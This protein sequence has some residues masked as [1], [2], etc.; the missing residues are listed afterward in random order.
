MADEN[1]GVFKAYITR[2]GEGP[3][4]TELLNET[5]DKIR[6]IGAEFGT[7]TGRPRRCGWFDGVVAKY[8]V[9]VSGLT[10]IAVT[11]LD[12]FDNFDEIKFCVAYRDKRDGTVYKYYPTNINLHKHLEPVYETFAGWKQSISNAKTFDEL[13]Q[14]AKRYLKRME[15]FLGIPV[16]IVSVGEDREQTIILKKPME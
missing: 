12:V 8:S 15:E 16:N 7:T 4:M 9:L 10:S 1:I 11:K 14:N 13:P 2:V 5:G 6:N 3:F